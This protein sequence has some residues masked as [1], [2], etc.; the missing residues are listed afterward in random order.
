MKFF[1]NTAILSLLFVHISHAQVE[2]DIMRSYQ[3]QK[4]SSYKTW[5][6]LSPDQSKLKGFLYEK[7]DSSVIIR[8][9][10]KNFREMASQEITYDDL[11][12]LP[13]DYSSIPITNIDKM[14]AR[15][16]G[17]V[18][19]GVFIG[20]LTGFAVGGL[21]GAI[22]GDDPPDTYMALTAG[23]KAL[24]LGMPLAAVGAGVGGLLGSFKLTIPIN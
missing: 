11:L 12:N 19:R 5:I 9:G 23:E 4:D 14:K 24:I 7:N 3:F 8:E 6:T 22:S 16:K 2:Q 17:R 18:G 20:A 10:F 1:F 15:K 21:I 13:L